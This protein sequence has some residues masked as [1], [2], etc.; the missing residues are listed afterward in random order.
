MFFMI[1]PT[2]ALY[3]LAYRRDAIGAYNINNLEQILGLFRGCAES[4]APFIIQISKGARNYADKRMLEAMIR[5]AEQ[6]HPEDTTPSETV[7]LDVI[8]GDQV[9]ACRDGDSLGTEGSLA[10]EVFAGLPGVS[11]RHLFFRNTGENW[12]A[13]APED[14]GSIARVDDQVIPPGQRVNLN[15]DHVLQIGEVRLKA[16]VTTPEKSD[17]EAEPMQ[18]QIEDVFS[19]T[20]TWLERAMGADHEKR[21]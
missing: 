3:K 20:A 6:I 18:I 21:E 12:F 4:Q 19:R 8:I 11:G 7:R 13:E 17:D 15:G 14:P 16:H 5:T 10:P 1:V 2:A 9:F